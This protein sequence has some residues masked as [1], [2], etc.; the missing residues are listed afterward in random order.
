[1]LWDAFHFLWV[2]V[3]WKIFFLANQRV[4]FH[5]KNQ[6]VRE[7]L[8]T[9]LNL[10]SNFSYNSIAFS[11]I[12]QSCYQTKPN[13]K[14]TTCSQKLPKILTWK[15]KRTNEESSLCIWYESYDGCIW[16]VYLEKDK[17]ISQTEVYRRNWFYGKICSRTPLQ[18]EITEAFSIKE[19]L[20]E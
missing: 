13:S 20:I 15:S 4:F 10:F 18:M 8:T 16:L 5:R 19:I 3:L 12:F 1:M 9:Y 6:K 11:I 14:K 17:K 2:D 7:Y